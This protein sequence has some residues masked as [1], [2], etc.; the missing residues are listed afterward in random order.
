MLFE[1]A[2]CLRLLLVQ[3]QVLLAVGRCWFQFGNL[4]FGL[5]LV[6]LMMFC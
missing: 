6:H 1:F 5:M 4:H 3:L 2:L